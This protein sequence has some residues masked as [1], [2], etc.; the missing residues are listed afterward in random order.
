MRLGVDL[1]TGKGALSVV[2][3]TEIIFCV[4][5]FFVD[6]IRKNVLYTKNFVYIE[7]VH[8]LCT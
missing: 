7:C 6:K 1:M 3:K 4:Q 2:H 5:G 8:I